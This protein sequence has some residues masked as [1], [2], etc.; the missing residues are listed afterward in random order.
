MRAL[1]L[2][3][4]GLCLAAAPA[5]AD[6]VVFNGTVANTCDLS[7][8]L[9]LT[10]TLALSS[11]HTILGSDQTGGIPVSLTVGSIGANTI[12]VGAP[13]LTASPVGYASAGQSLEIGYLGAGL[14]SLVNKP[15]GPGGGSFSAGLLGLTGSTILINARVVNANGFKLGDYQITSVVTCS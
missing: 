6:N 14:L 2:A 8:M 4:V 5:S 15:M 1:G 12:T 7:I 13:S 11:D 3:I 10:G 9:P